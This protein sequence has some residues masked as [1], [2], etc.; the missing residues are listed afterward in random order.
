VRPRELTLNGFRSYADEVT[1]EWTD[2]RLVGIVGP[3]GSGK[4][5]ILDA[6]AFALYGKTPR[7]E[8]DTKSLIN[9][10]RDAL[11][12]AMTFDVEGAVWKAVRVLRRSGASSHVLYRMEGDEPVEVTDKSREMAEHVET[13]LGL[14]FDGFRRSVLLAQNQFATF[15]EA[16]GTERNQVLKGVF[17]FERLDAMRAITKERLEQADRSLAT[18]AGRRSSSDADVRDL[19]DKRVRLAAAEE[20]ERA[21]EELRVPFEETKAVRLASQAKV[22][23]ADRRLAR[24]DELD[25]RLPDPERAAELASEGEAASRRVHERRAAVDEAEQVRRNAAE[26]RDQALEAAGGRAGLDAVAEV[27]AEWRAARRSVEGHTEAL[28]EARKRLD[29]AATEARALEQR[30]V[31]AERRRAEAQDAHGRTLQ[32]LEDARRE[33]TSAQQEHR[34]HALQSELTVGQPCPVCDQPVVA[35]PERTAPPSLE[36]AQRQLDVADRDR[37]ETERAL[38]AASEAAAEA[39]SSAAVAKEQETSAAEAVAEREHILEEAQADV[40]RLAGVAAGH[41]GPGDP[42]ERL[43]DVR[44]GLDEAEQALAVAAAAEEQARSEAAEADRGEVEV[45][46]RLSTIRAEVAAVAGALDLPPGSV[47]GGLGAAVATVQ[48]AWHGKRQAAEGDRA[49]ASEERTAADA[50]LGELLEAAGLGAGDDVVEVIAAARAERSG[51]EAEVQ[52][53]EKRLAELETLA[54]DEAAVMA[55]AALLRTLHGDLAPSRFL[56]FVLDERRRALGELASE[57]L[58]V[59]TGGRYRF[60]ESGDFQMVDLT[61]ANAVRAPSSLSGGETFL[62]SLGL[63]LALAEIVAREGGRL[64]SFFLDEGFGSLDPEHLDLAMDG[65]ERLVTAGPDRLVVLVSHVPAMRDRIEDLV[66]LDR[67]PITGNTQVV[68]G[69]S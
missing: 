17:G 61:A 30:L 66:V 10:R 42:E 14:D 2:R 8:R 23:D 64:D 60:D 52:L 59:L 32:A 13:L 7:I 20:R 51:I 16:T 55:S 39:G 5:S 46:E 34:A 22:E 47:D 26:A 4:S 62:A 28:D 33:L 12:V 65:V 43:S 45:R 18:L 67:D 36:E 49:R 58:E 3:I 21:L 41:L 31:A 44:R 53:L 63:A 29:A 27:V 54:R 1:F 56:E 11:H 25:E 24:L 48:E 9:Q 37:L 68:A 50:A 57:H 69:G 19:E 40:A 6:I 15:L 35:I 38:A